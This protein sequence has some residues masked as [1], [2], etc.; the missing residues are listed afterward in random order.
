[1]QRGLSAEEA[2]ALVVNGF[3]KDVLQQLPMEFALR[4][5]KL[6]SISLRAAVGWEP[7]RAGDEARRQAGGQR[8]TMNDDRNGN[9]NASA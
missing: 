6:I 1:M 3:V 2:V 9:R 8:P 5:Q 4:G 7:E